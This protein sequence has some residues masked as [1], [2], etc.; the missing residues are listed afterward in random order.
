MDNDRKKEMRARIRNM[1]DARRGKHA[2]ARKQ[3]NNNET[4][5][6]KQL[7]SKSI[8]TLLKQLKIDQPHIKPQLQQAFQKG[9]ITNVQDLA[10]FLTQNT[11]LDVTEK[12]ILTQLQ[13]PSPTPTFTAPPPYTKDSL[14][15]SGDNGSNEQM[16]KKTIRPP[17]ETFSQE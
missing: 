9:Q 13:G 2:N 14:Q 16:K 6:Q 17:S 5:E 10:K 11:K 4:E 8:D 3:Q 1:Q 12:D 15:N 7:A